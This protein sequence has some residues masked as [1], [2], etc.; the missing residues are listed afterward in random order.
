MNKL[1]PALVTTLGLLLMAT[2]LVGCSNDPNCDDRLF[3][4][5]DRA[6]KPGYRNPETGAC[7]VLG[8]SGGSGGC[9][10]DFGERPTSAEALE[11]APDQ[12]L[13]FQSC[14]GLVEL[15]CL[16]TEMCRGIYSPTG[17]FA[18][19]WGTAPSGPSPASIC[20]GLEAYDCSRTD[21]CSATHAQGRENLGN[22]QSCA[23]E[24]VVCTSSTDCGSGSSCTTETQQECLS[25]GGDDVCYGYCEPNSQDPG[26]CVGEVACDLPE[27]ACP[28]GTIAG[29]DADCWTG[30][31]IPVAECDAT[32]ACS[33][34]TE[35]D[36]STATECSGLYRGIDCT[37]TG[38]DCTCTSYEYEGC[39]DNP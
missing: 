24:K 17:E 3:A 4:E 6:P 13:C 16:L 10:D 12:A 19:C 26:S 36:C 15:D 2:A 31:C 22:F 27:P 32:P 8:G 5:A 18:E 7:E 39:A 29:R 35:S 21:H 38:S 25:H 28:D 14:E 1:V 37:C 30:Y 20:D 23:D 34:L 9:D 33:S 11:A